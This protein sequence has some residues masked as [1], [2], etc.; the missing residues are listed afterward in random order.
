MLGLFDSSKSK[1]CILLWMVGVFL[2][3]VGEQVTTSRLFPIYI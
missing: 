2:T 1:N 3:I